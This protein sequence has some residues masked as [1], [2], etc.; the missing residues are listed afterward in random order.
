MKFR[1]IILLLFATIVSLASCSD[2]ESFTLSPSRLLTFSA[3]SIKL[4]TLFSNVPSRTKDF[5]VYNRSGEGIRCTNIR[6]ER[7]NQSGFRVNVD[8]SYLGAAVGFQ[9]SNVELR[10][11]DSIRIFVEATTPYN[12]QDKPQLVEDNLLFTL[13]SG[14]TQKVNLNAYSWDAQLLSNVRISRDSVLSATDKPVVVY[15]GITVDSAATLTLAAGSTFYFHA[16][17]GIDV[18][19]TLIAEGTPEANIVLRG[20]RLDRMFDNLTYDQISGQW[21][22]LHFQSSSYGNRLVYTDIHSPFDG[23]VADSSDVERMKLEMVCSTIHSC[24]GYGLHAINSRIKLEN[25]QI[26]NTQNDCLCLDGGWADVNACTIAQFYPFQAINFIGNALHFTAD[27]YNLLMLSCQNSLITGWGSIQLR[28]EQGDSATICNYAFANCIIRDTTKIENVD[29][30]KL[31]RNVVFENDSDM[32]T[33][34][35]K[36]FIVTESSY[37]YDFR[38]D[39]LSTAIDKGDPAT[40]PPIDRNG[41][42]RDER[43]DIGAFEYKKL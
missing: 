24:Q 19:G 13:E 30:V 22:G 40:A 28:G 11:K 21:K 33:A 6:L 8:G 41:L 34:Y 39:S 20:D 42:P 36:H 25:C 18:H 23:I 27:R 17:A 31:F 16:D 10:N 12:Y 15:G 2:D 43:P 38:L 9:T 29:T 35:K 32:T 4:D 5:W 26:T 3:D 14:V 1:N 37:S 7:G